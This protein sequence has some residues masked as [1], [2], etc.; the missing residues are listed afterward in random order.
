MRAR[1]NWAERLCVVR[2]RVVWDCGRQST[3]QAAIA[4]GKCAS[5]AIGK[6]CRSVR[7]K[8]G[9]ITSPYEEHGAK[10]F[11]FGS[12]GVEIDIMR[13]AS[14]AALPLSRYPNLNTIAVIVEIP[15]TRGYATFA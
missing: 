4:A 11:F 5:G 15:K 9:L 14:D 2:E 1:G 6:L 3:S 7:E 13:Q 12:C 8:S 10:F